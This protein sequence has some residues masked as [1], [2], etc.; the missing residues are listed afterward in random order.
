M[1][2][3]N[4]FTKGYEMKNYLHNIPKKFHNEFVL[5]M[6]ANDMEDLP[7]G[8]WWAMLEE[9]AEEFMK[10]R[11]IKGCSNDAVHLYLSESQS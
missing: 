2:D 6:A 9:A 10:N 4:I 1:Y 7:D 8:A 3:R 11:Q 5:W